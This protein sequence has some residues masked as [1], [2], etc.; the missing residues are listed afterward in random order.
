MSLRAIAFD[1]DGTLYPDI[2]VYL[3]SIPLFAVHPRFLFAFN[4]MRKE[5]RK[6]DTIENLEAMQ[7]KML[8]AM[9]GITETRAK[10]L[11]SSIVYKKWENYYKGIKP[12]R[13][14]KNTLVRL[15]EAGYK[16]GLLSDFPFQSK[17]VRLG[18]D[19]IWDARVSSDDVNHLKPN[20]EPFLLLQKRLD[21]PVHE[22]LYVGDRHKYDVVGAKNAGMMAAHFTKKT[23]PES[24]A[25]F[26]FYDFEDLYRYVS[27]LPKH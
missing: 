17:L 6:I 2:Y 15:K 23:K 24:S 18:L 4:K 1:L 5:I 11:I 27:Q 21:V 8:G 14:V 20:S 9:L 25:D 12:F 3:R 26:T 22:I 13:G 16:L 10:S 7:A 19:D